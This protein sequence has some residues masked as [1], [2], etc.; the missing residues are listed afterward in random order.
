[1]LI[2]PPGSGKSTWASA[3][4]S[5][6]SWAHISTDAW[7]EN[8]AVRKS[9]T[10]NEIFQQEIK[11]AEI[12]MEAKLVSALAQG[13]GIIW[14]QTNMGRHIR[15][16]KIGRLLDAG[17]TVEAHVFMPSEGELQVRQL[18]RA[19]RTGKVIPQHIVDTMLEEYDPPSI[20]EGFNSIVIHN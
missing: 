14:D 20:E 18:Q 11:N 1:M 12:N 7:I 9:V 13:D 3:L 16:N 5:Y 2:G 4:P 17:Y 6:D 19:A 10:Y 8:M 15:L